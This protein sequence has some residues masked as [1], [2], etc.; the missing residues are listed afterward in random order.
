MSRRKWAFTGCAVLVVLMV[1]IVLVATPAAIALRLAGFRSK[2]RTGDFLDERASAV[3]PTIQWSGQAAAL[4]TPTAPADGS[5]PAPAAPAGSGGPSD[6][7]PL[8]RVV[9]DIWF[10]SQPTAFSAGDTFAR[11][12]ERG[13]IEDGAL[14]YYIEF[15]QAGI[16]TYLNCWF[17]GYVAQEPRVRNVWLDLKPGGAIVYAE[18]DLEVGWQGVGAVFMLDAS[19]RQLIL[20]GVDMDGRLYSTP[21]EGQVASLVARLESESN[22]ALRELAF[23]D[24]AGRLTVQ[25]ISLGEDLVQI[26]AY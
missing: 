7:G 14:A 9:V 3:P 2:G 17:G 5:A 21:P 23:V 24:P 11:R 19:G 22:R 13:R 12:L 8:D 25:R 16:N 6:V 1:G 20:A 4:P 10:L 15:D 18:V 26:L